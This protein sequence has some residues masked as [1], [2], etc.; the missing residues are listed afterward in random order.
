[1]KQLFH[2]FSFFWITCVCKSFFV[3]FDCKCLPEDCE[4]YLETANEFD[5]SKGLLTKD[6]S[7]T[8]FDFEPNLESHLITETANKNIKKVDARIAFL[9]LNDIVIK[10]G[11]ESETFTD[12]IES[13]TS[14][15]SMN[16]TWLAE[17]DYPKERFQLSPDLFQNIKNHQFDFDF[18]DDIQVLCDLSVE[19][20]IINI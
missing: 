3:S 8:R 18:G 11:D 14:M 17:L 2:I 5:T 10:K 7:I 1:M 4:V 19:E 20:E 12:G 16:F 6:V 15:F 9:E 13:K